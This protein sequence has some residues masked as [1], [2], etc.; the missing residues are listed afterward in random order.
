MDSKQK[1]RTWI[2]IASAVIIVIAGVVYLVMTTDPN[3]V[4][5]VNDGYDQYRDSL[6]NAKSAFD[7]GEALFLDVRTRGEFADAH[8]T[9]AV[10]IPLGELAENEPNVDKGA[11]IY[12]Y[13]T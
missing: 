13:C 9:G 7:K 11:L 12:T 2:V 5:A 4:T 3:A 6:T 10:S 8:I 1:T